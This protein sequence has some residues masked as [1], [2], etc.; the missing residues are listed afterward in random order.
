[1]PAYKGI[2]LFVLCSMQGIFC[3][4]TGQRE[5]LGF[6]KADRRRAGRKA[7]TIPSSVEGTRPCGVCT[8]VLGGNRGSAS[9]KLQ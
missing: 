5:D 9:K 4:K 7:G 2:L 1:M 3:V 6:H 8:G